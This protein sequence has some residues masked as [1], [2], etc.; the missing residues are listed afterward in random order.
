MPKQAIWIA[1]GFLLMGVLPLPYGYYMVLRL[2][3]CSV[4][5]WAAYILFMRNEEL[6]PWVF[7]VLAIVFN[8]ILIIHFPKE[9]W[10]T[11]DF[12]SAVFLI[13]NRE[14]ILTDGRQGT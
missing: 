12:C 6:L 11:I 9:I 2:I 1:A 8:P 10:G 3:A 5:S 4:F 14:K 7:V 13:L